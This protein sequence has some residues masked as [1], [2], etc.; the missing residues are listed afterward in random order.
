[1]KTAKKLLALLLAALFVSAL[2]ACGKTPEPESS[3]APSSSQGAPE[4]S[5][6][7]GVDPNYTVDTEGELPEVPDSFFHEAMDAYSWFEGAQID[8]IDNIPSKT[9][10]HAY[11]VEDE[12]YRRFSDFRDYLLTLFS[13]ALVNELLSRDIYFD[14]EGYT[15]VRQFPYTVDKAVIKV[16]LD[17]GVIVGRKLIYT[18]VVT[19]GDMQTLE[20][21]DTQTFEF[22]AEPVGGRF[23]FTEFPYFY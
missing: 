13:P 16:D 8:P 19:F 2:C 7:Y 6:D 20:P 3:G 4:S 18:A 17:D 21:I 23:V 22:V 10:E 11:L 9:Q 12:A 5:S 1:M 14:E 15:Y